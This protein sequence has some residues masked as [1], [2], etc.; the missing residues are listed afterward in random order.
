MT[1]LKKSELELLLQHLILHTVLN[2]Y[3][4]Y[5]KGMK[6]LK[7]SSLSQELLRDE[8]LNSTAVLLAEYFVT[9]AP[10]IPQA[11]KQ[12]PEM[13]EF[14]VWTERECERLKKEGHVRECPCPNCEQ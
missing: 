6:A 3:H 8:I 5:E 1:R 14:I 4:T 2:G 7:N 9:I 11:L 12:L 13:S 10:V